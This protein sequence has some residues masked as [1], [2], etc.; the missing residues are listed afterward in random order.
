M[1][2]CKGKGKGKGKGKENCSFARCS[3]IDVGFPVMR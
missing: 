1:G 2:S 3:L